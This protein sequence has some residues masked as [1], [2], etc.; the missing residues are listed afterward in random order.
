MKIVKHICAAATLLCGIASAQATGGP[1][2]RYLFRLDHSNFEGHSCALLQTSGVFH[3]EINDGDRVRVFE[4]TI[5]ADALTKLE[6]NLN[7]SALTNLSQSQI[8]EPLIWTRH[9]ELQLSILRGETW[10]DLFFQSS[11]SQQTFKHS[12][13][14]LIHWL[15]T[16]SRVP[17]RELSEDEG[18][19]R[20]LPVGTIALKK[21]GDP[22]PQSIT[23]RTTM[24]VLYGGPTPQPRPQPALPIAPQSVSPLFLLNS[25]ERRSESA[26]EWCVVIGENGMYRFEDRAQKTGKPVKT[27][28]TAGQIAPS[29]LQQLHQLLDDPTLVSIRHHEPPGHGDVPMMQDKL[30]LFIARPAGVQHFILSSHFNRPD[31]LSFYRGDADVT[32]AQPLLKFLS[33]HVENNPAGVLDSSK[34]NSCAEAP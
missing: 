16:L 21:R 24:H 19:N 28:V 2:Y 15:D 23:A 32:A 7:S 1:S 27:R 12:L 10:Q 34:R 17:H 30:D 5:T 13:Q 20:C 18:A 4:G 22:P 25:F 11:D 29:E 31:F 8:E 26:H 9:D 14:P 3:L 33:E 6:S